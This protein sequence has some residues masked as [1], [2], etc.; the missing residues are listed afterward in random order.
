ML[1]LPLGLAMNRKYRFMT[2]AIFFVLM[3]PSIFGAHLDMMLGN[4]NRT[5]GIGRNL[6]DGRSFGSV[7]DFVYGNHRVSAS[8]TGVTVKGYRTDSGDIRARHDSLE[9]GYSYL[10]SWNPGHEE[11]RLQPYA[12][13]SIVGNLGLDWVQNAVHE[14]LGRKKVYLPYD[15]EKVRV[16]PS[17]GMECGWLHDFH[18]G[19]SIGFSD[20]FS[21]RMQLG[22]YDDVSL[23]FRFGEGLDLSLG[24]AFEKNL[25]GGCNTQEVQ[26]I[27]DTGFFLSASIRA[28]LLVLDYRTNLSEKV[29]YGLIGV[30]PLAFMDME[31][32]RDTGRSVSIGREWGYPSYMHRLTLSLQNWQLRMKYRTSEIEIG[33]EKRVA[34]SSFALGYDFIWEIGQFSPFIAPWGGMSQYVYFRQNWT[35]NNQD[36]LIEHYMPA[37]GLDVGVRMLEKGFLCAGGSS[38]SLDAGLSLGWNIGAESVDLDGYDEFAD[39]V[40]PIEARFFLDLVFHI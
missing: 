35:T 10:F 5:F 38:F 7:V 8:L 15:Y 11:L 32:F 16:F 12:G 20:R 17:L 14:V 30:D 21:Y 40:S 24:Y 34:N 31:S 25:T 23:D 4:D 27:R 22:F 18:D 2:L 9:L 3:L 37:I 39:R 6:D 33:S 13:V 36:I 29:S 26:A 19:F 28:G 1:F